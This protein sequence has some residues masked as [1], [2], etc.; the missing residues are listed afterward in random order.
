MKKLVMT[1]VMLMS[2]A[3]TAQAAD[4]GSNNSQWNRDGR[5]SGTT[6]TPVGNPTGGLDGAIALT[7]G[8]RLEILIDKAVGRVECTLNGYNDKIVDQVFNGKAMLRFPVQGHIPS[9]QGQFNGKYELE[10]RITA[11]N[12]TCPVWDGSLV[13]ISPEHRFK[14]N[15]KFMGSMPSECSGTRY[16]TLKASVRKSIHLMPAAS[17]TAGLRSTE[18]QKPVRSLRAPIRDQQTYFQPSVSCEPEHLDQ[19]R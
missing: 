10:C 16:P 7:P 1:L 9:D 5:F 8:D 2:V 4:Y 6:N 13:Q 15:Q 18:R 3:Q 19:N 14:F 11:V 12:G 17:R